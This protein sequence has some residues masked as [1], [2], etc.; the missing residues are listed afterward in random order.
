MLL[1]QNKWAIID[2]GV[3][4]DL[5][6]VVQEGVSG[7]LFSAAWRLLNPDDLWGLSFLKT[8]F[9]DDSLTWFLK[10]WFRLSSS[11]RYS[12]EDEDFSVWFGFSLDVLTFPLPL[13]RPLLLP[14]SPDLIG[15]LSLEAKFLPFSRE[16]PRKESG[17]ISGKTI[18]YHGTSE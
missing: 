18:V 8:S 16:P 13:K 4:F 7:E 14:F 1:L 10:V 5:F 3:T 11:L 17:E 6:L 2:L 9:E 12:S 15:V